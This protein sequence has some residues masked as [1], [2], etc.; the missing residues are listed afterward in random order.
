MIT[1][2]L[3]N[4]FLQSK[5][6]NAGIR[7]NPGV[8]NAIFPWGKYQLKVNKKDVR[9]IPMSIALV[10]SWL[11][12]RRHLPTTFKQGYSFYCCID[13][14]GNIYH[15]KAQ[16]QTGKGHKQTTQK[17][18]SSSNRFMKSSSEFEELPS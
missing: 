15:A 11:T 13:F 8:I 18:K 4:D 17:R 1:K 9:N 6:K 3:Y 7:N 12:M 2:K 5:S 10:S 14:W 16:N